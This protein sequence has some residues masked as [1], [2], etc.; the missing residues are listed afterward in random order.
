MKWGKHAPNQEPL[1][2]FLWGSGGGDYNN[3]TIGI[4]QS[5]Y[6]CCCGGSIIE[7]HHQK[8][9]SALDVNHMDVYHYK[10]AFTLSV[11]DSSVESPNTMLV[12]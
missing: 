11:R 2:Y 3:S 7:A 4:M 8:K 5:E 6:F 1:V 10:S 9:N 12:N